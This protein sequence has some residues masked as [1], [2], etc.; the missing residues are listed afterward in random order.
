LHFVY[1]WSILLLIMIKLP[2]LS[3]P[4]LKLS[5]VAVLLVV[6]GMLVSL[7]AG[8]SYYFYREN[9]R[10]TGLLENPT[11]AARVEVR[12][13][14]ERVGRLMIL[15][16]DEE[17]TLATVIDPQ[18]LAD[19]PFFA[20]AKSGDKV[21]IYTTNKKAILYRPGDNK[22]LEVAP[23]TIGQG[24]TPTDAMANQPA[25]QVAVS[26]TPSPTVT[27]TVGVALLNGTTIT[28]ITAKAETTLKGAFPEITVVAKENANAKTHEKTLVVD[29]T[30]GHASLARKIAGQL[31][32][33]VTAIPAGE[34][35]PQPEGSPVDILVILGQSV[36]GASP[37]PTP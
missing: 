3:L 37:S 2:K 13:T 10:V 26:P 32:G 8:A 24:Q 17:P 34:T 9:K 14:V 12:S 6:A 36:T 31:S 16:T 33:E 29:V 19:Q 4:R 1:E 35:V 11:E 25:D 5:P 20:K 30:G 23:I 27:Q 21:L 7:A 18:K 22:I 28:G 15:P